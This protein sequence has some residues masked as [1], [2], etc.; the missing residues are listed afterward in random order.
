MLCV[1]IV[2]LICCLVGIVQT[3]QSLLAGRVAVLVRRLLDQECPHPFQCMTGYIVMLFG[4]AV[5]IV[6]QSN[7]VFRSAL[8]P[9]VG[10]GIVTLDR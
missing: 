2:A 7:S 4:M 10:I 9:L 6:V 5:V 1:A 8:T 3:M